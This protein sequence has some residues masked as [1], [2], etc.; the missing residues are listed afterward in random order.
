MRLRS[1]ISAPYCSNSKDEGCCECHEVTTLI[2]SHRT[3]SRWRIS[4][5]GILLTTV[6]ATINGHIPKVVIC[7]AVHSTPSSCEDTGHPKAPFQSY[8]SNPKREKAEQRTKLRDHKSEST[9]WN[10][11]LLLMEFPQDQETFSPSHLLCI[12]EAKT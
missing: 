1:L 3:D 2:C 12:K 9:C 8:R 7:F 11:K 5:F 6:L 10:Q 4:R